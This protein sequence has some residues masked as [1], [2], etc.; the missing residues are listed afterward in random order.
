M[1]TYADSADAL[2]TSRNPTHTITTRVYTANAD[3]HRVELQ[4]TERTAIAYPP[5]NALNTEPTC[6]CP[7]H[8]DRP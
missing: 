7:I 2:G 3:G 1:T 4:P 8:R 6:Q 5:S